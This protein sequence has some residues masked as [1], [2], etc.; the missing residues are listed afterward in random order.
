MNSYLFFF[1]GIHLHL[2]LVSFKIKI[3]VSKLV[4]SAHQEGYE[5][6]LYVYIEFIQFEHILTFR[7]HKEREGK[8]ITKAHK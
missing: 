5:S 6:I 4:I 2:Q 1:Q 3:Q 8:A 7:K